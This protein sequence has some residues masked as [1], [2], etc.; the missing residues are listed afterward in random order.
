MTSNFFAIK[1]GKLFT[2]GD[3]ILLGTVRDL[4]IKQCK[5]H[6]VEV[7]LCPPSLSDIEAWEGCMISST[8][9]LALPVDEIIV[10]GT[11]MAGGSNTSADSVHTFANKGSLVSQIDSWV[12][13]AIE[14]SSE[15]L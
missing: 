2:A 7:Q 15:P 14:S 9:R 10:D 6:G 12:T 13:S 4:V 11:L 5:E 8:S 3:G 1:G